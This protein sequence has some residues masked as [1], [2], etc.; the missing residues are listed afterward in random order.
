[1]D[2]LNEP[3][4]LDNFVYQCI[5]NSVLDKPVF[6]IPDPYEFI[7]KQTV[8]VSKFGG[9]PDPQPAGPTIELEAP[10]ADLLNPSAVFDDTML[11]V[12]FDFAL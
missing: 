5:L 4:G 8:S 11:H 2:V 6:E 7:P 12:S 3:I 10:R 1:M 9:F